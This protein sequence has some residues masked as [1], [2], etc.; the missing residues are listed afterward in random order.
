MDQWQKSS[1]HADLCN[2]LLA[3]SDAVADT[4]I[5]A[6]FP[7]SEAVCAIVTM[8]KALGDMVN[9]FPPIQQSMRF[10][11]KAFA[12]WHAKL[13][14]EAAGLLA[15][16]LPKDPAVQEA[17]VELVPYLLDSF[18]NATRI[19]YG[20]GHEANFMAF[21]LCLQKLGVIGEADMT[22]LGLFVFVEYVAVMR[23]IQ[24]VY[25]MEPAGSHGVWGL[26]DYHFLPFLWGAS[27][28]QSSQE[29]APADVHDQE[30]LAEFAHE[31]LY[32][33]AIQFIYKVKTG[34]P[35]TEHSPILYSISQ[36]APAKGWPKV[37]EGFKKMYYAEVLGKL[38]VIQHF[39]FGSL[40]PADW[41]QEQ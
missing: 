32:L 33:D 6:D 29:I 30:L 39:L 10:G 8:L 31:Y 9:E 27:Q 22:A 41:N 25:V 35:F 26:D 21:L 23:K 38:P 17:V 14:E 18:G 4:K 24:S 16:M 11:N 20:T 37:C 1:T 28:L 12:S 5:S 19:D 36:I 15:E 3:I 40:L 2:F 7:R 34:G 13:Q